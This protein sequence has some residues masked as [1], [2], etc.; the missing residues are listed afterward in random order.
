MLS[1]LDI[2]SKKFIKSTFGGYSK[3]DVEKFMELILVDYE[4]LYRENIALKDK[5]NTLSD[6]VDHYKSME[7]TMQSTLLVAQS[8]SDEVK[9]N[10][11][12]KARLIVEEANGKAGDIIKTANAEMQKSAEKTEQLKRD[13]ILFKSRI[14]AEFETYLK[15]MKS[16]MGNEEVNTENKN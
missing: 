11:A 16:N 13:Y 4:K 3:A 9:S 5:A 6:A 15:T 12:E 2:E 8:A 1:P 14:I 7:D 10:A